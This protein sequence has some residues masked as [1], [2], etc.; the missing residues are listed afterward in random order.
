M[1]LAPYRKII[2]TLEFIAL[3]VLIGSML[4]FRKVAE[5]H[6]LT[7]GLWIIPISASFFVISGFAAN[8]Y[9]RWIESPESQAATATQKIFVWLVILSLYGVW[10][11]AVGQAFLLQQQ[12]TR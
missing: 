6:P 12:I 9:I 10:F 7:S 3:A 4:V 11:I 1:R 2:L 5:N 8:L